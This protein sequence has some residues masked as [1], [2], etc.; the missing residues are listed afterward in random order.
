MGH[1]MPSRLRDREQPARG[2]RGPVLAMVALCALL[3]GY[4][5]W[6]PQGVFVANTADDVA[7]SATSILA[8]GRRAVWLRVVLQGRPR[9]PGHCCRQERARGRPGSC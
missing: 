6:Q 4:I 2:L 5:A 7:E 9:R 8:R 3:A 1:V